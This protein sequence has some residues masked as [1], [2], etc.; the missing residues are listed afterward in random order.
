MFENDLMLVLSNPDDYWMGLSQKEVNDVSIIRRI[1]F[2]NNQQLCL[3][4]TLF[5]EHMDLDGRVEC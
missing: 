4:K 3:I 5:Q 1:Y 2:F